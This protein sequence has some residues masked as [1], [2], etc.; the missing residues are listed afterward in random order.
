MRKIL[1]LACLLAVTVTVA[2]Q[3]C[4]DMACRTAERVL[5]KDA[6][7]VYVQTASATTR[8]K[9]G[10]P[11]MYVYNGYDGKGFAIVSADDDATLLAYSAE[12]SFDAEDIPPACRE[13]MEGYRHKVMA[14]A[15]DAVSPMLTSRWGQGFPFNMKCPNDRRNG[16]EG[17]QCLTGCTSTA[18]AQ[19]MYY[20]RYPERPMGSVFYYDGKQSV[21]REMDFDSQPAFDWKNMADVYGST[22]VIEQCN[23]VAQLLNCITLSSK[24]DFGSDV[25]LANT[26]NAV[27]RMADYMGYSKGIVHYERKDYSDEEWV[28]IILKELKEGRPVIY[29]G[30]NTSMGHA[31]VCDGYDG[32]GLFHINWGWYGKSDGY[33]SLSALNPEEQGE[34]G[35]GEGYNASQSIECGIS[36][37]N[38]TGIGC[39]TVSKPVV[40]V[41]WG[42]DGLWHVTAD[43][44]IRRIE[45][46]S[47]EG[48]MLY[49]VEPYS[50]DV[51]IPSHSE[52]YSIMRILTDNY[53][54]TRKHK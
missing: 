30:R 43:T 1:I 48:M 35:S 16:Y 13:W 8:G 28:G 10:E 24:V 11:Q 5:G 54:V 46:F 15:S 32:K 21:W 38:V 53:L 27:A 29:S 22:P 36:P 17:R 42:T 25:T 31:F 23:A 2:G 40:R 51:T 37:T 20:Y 41:T 14:E 7:L 4:Q 33:F 44:Q 34:G 18:I 47:V 12:N 19:V 52:K 6:V 39:N 50:P 9:G 3:Q 26:K 49:S 45:I